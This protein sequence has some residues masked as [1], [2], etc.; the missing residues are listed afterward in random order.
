MMEICRNGCVFLKSMEAVGTIIFCSLIPQS[1]LRA[2]FSL[3]E[4]NPTVEEAESYGRRELEEVSSALPHKHSKCPTSFQEV[5]NI[6]QVNLQLEEE[7]ETLRNDAIKQ[8]T[9]VLIRDI[10]QLVKEK[11]SNVESSRGQPLS[12]N[13]RGSQAGGMWLVRHHA[14]PQ[15]VLSQG[16]GPTALV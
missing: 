1:H 14:T 7:T 13:S 4:G 15:C 10:K 6:K 11:D 12:A 16:G 8:D 9:S 2:H 3:W 5:T